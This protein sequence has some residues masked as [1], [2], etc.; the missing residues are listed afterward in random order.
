MKFEEVKGSELKV[1]DRIIP[2]YRAT[3]TILELR[4]CRGVFAAILGCR[5]ADDTFK[6]RGMSINTSDY[7][8]RVIPE[9]TST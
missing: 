8:R 2:W 5:H 3:T 7:Y 1:G 9:G 6:A 4:M